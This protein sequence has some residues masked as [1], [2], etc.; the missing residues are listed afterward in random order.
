MIYSK[1][2]SNEFFLLKWKI[3]ERKT[4]YLC[5]FVLGLCAF[6]LSIYIMLIWNEHNRQ[7]PSHP[8]AFGDFFALWSYA[9]IASTYSPSELYDLSVLHARQVALGMVATAQN[10]FPYPP[11]F[12]LLIWPLSFFPYELSY[13][14][15]IT[16]TMALFM[17]AIMATCSR[18]PVCVLG[19]IVAPASVATISAG[20]SGFLSAA[21]IVVGLRLASSRPV[22]GGILI[23]ILTFKPQLG[24]LIPIAL[25]AAGY[26]T[27]FVTACVATLVLSAL[28]TLAF[29]W[30]IW[31]AWV[32]MMPAYVEMFDQAMVGRNFMP[33][34]IVDL[35]MAGVSLIVAKG[36]QVVV[37]LIVATLVWRRFRQNAGKLATAALLVGTFLAT[38]HA[39][40]YD[41][42][43]IVAALALF[44]DVRSKEASAFSLAEIV[45]MVFVFVFPALMMIKGFDY[46]VG[47]LSLAL[48]FSL[49]LWHARLPACADMPHPA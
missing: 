43:M 20:Q 17:W 1:I 34:V 31:P 25:V 46:P 24:F 18:L 48:F 6:I 19:A 8:A 10:P 32:S 44:I 26:W 16:G 42:P 36:V 27:A 40:I 15:W 21:L 49:I 39:F 28:A 30:A 47:I 9:Q 4:I 33:T 5:A 7:T 14:L 29:G 13:V 11:A 12:I 38:P 2:S 3:E 45:I 35:Q 37:G 23:G 22:W 41:L